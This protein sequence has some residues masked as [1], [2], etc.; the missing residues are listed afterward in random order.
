MINVDREGFF[1]GGFADRQDKMRSLS[2]TDT[3]LNQGQQAI[4]LRAQSNKFDQTQALNQQVTDAIGS[5]LNQISEI[6]KLYI[7][8]GVSPDDPRLI[9]A[10]SP[11]VSSAENLAMRAEEAG[12]PGVSS[13]T[14]SALVEKNLNQMSTTEQARLQGKASGAAKGAQTNSLA[15]ELGISRTQAMQAEGYLPKP[16]RAPSPKAPEGYRWT[17]DGNLEFI[18]GGPKDPGSGG[19]GKPMPATALKIENELIADLGIATGVQSDLKAFSDQIESGE[20]DLSFLKNVAAQA[21][22]AINKSDPQSRAYQSFRSSLE[23]LRND[24]LRLNKGVQ[25]EGD[26]QRA[27]NELFQNLNDEKFVKKRLDEIVNINERAADQKTLQINNV[28]ENYGKELF[29]REKVPSTPTIQGET[30]RP[31]TLEEFNAL[32]SGTVYIDPDDGQKYRKP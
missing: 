8:R 25:T 9:E 21:K 13:G 3:A 29:D 4:D 30:P 18:P 31:Q 20:L 28:R 16:D 1:M 19:G 14:I 12:I 17:G 2:Q 32:P 11:L 6:T 22:N 27:W 24:S 10:I 23:K 7:D 5:T 15:D 26:A